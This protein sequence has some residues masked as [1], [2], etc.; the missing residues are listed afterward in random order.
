MSLAPA[1]AAIA[2]FVLLGQTLSWLEIVGIALVIAAS[3]GAV[4]SSQ[5]AARSS[6]EPVG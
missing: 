4:R 2:G 1:T 3:I 5:R 6:A